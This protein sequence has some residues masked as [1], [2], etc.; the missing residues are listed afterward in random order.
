[1][2]TPLETPLN[3]ESFEALAQRRL[4]ATAWD[5]YRSGAW[6]EWT[7]R[8][9]VEA[10]RRLRLLPRA[11]IDVSRR[12]LS[13][14][15]LGMRLPC[16]LL[17]APTALQ[18]M[19]DPEGE[20]AT[21]RA[22]A[23]AGVPMVLSS[24]STRTVEDVAVAGVP[25][26]MQLYIAGDR[27]FTRALAQR[28][29]AAGCRALM[30]TVD[31]PVWGVRERDIHNGFRVPDGMSIVHLQRPGQPTGHQGRGIG[32]SLGWTIDASLTWKDL[33]SLKSAVRV[34]VLVK[35]VMRGDDAVRAFDHGADA[36]VVSNHGGRQLDGAAPTAEALAAV[37][38][39]SA[40]RGAVLVDGGIRRG[41]DI[42][43]ALALGA[44]AVMVGRPILWGLAAAGEA[45]VARV[46]EI[47]RQELDL[48][49]ALAGCP[50][51]AS[52]TRDL[53]LDGAESAAPR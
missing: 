24:L 51:R 14:S 30:V 31:T 34:P 7:V 16:P 21:A 43:R 5:Y 17:I 10:W 41:T 6:G 49:M 2:S 22:A 44:D 12:D 1:M 42:L 53:I 39:R 20:V 32:E 19:A 8:A 48:A 50:D 9:N 11:M 40:G 33:A 25:L 45:G 3:V 46:L 23:R 27:G 47:L 37:V 15:L 38:Q 13:C 26:L 35:G 52:I 4:D 28:A 18:Q 29:E 36:V